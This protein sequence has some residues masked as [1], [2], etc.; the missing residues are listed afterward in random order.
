MAQGIRLQKEDRFACKKDFIQGNNL[1]VIAG[2]REALGRNHE[3][4]ISEGG[5]E[6][7]VVGCMKLALSRVSWNDVKLANDCFRPHGGSWRGWL[8]TRDS[9]ISVQPI[10]VVGKS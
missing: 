10:R 8:L 7:L 4:T 5:V 9:E 2:I 1:G 3:S 6:E